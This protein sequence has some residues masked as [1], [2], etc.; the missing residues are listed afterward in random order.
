[1]IK[2]ALN[3]AR[4]ILLFRIIYP[5]VKHGRNV[6]VQFSSVFFSPRKHIVM[7]DNVGIGQFCVFN[8]DID[9]G[10][11]VLIAAHVGIIARDAHETHHIGIPMFDAPRGDRLH[12]KVDDDVWIG[13]GAIILS[14]VTIG[15]GAIV[16][17]GAVVTR[18]VLPYAVV[19]GN[20]A[21]VLRMRFNQ[22]QIEC[23]EATLY[24]A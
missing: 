9:I 23:H 17:A 10:S 19:G 3:W 15:R 16:A 1:M 13:F 6:H 18:D 20:P 7:G 22:S 2:R 4:N 24:G 14:G 11:N 21:S 12:V 8:T 5:W